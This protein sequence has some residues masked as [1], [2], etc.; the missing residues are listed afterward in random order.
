MRIG[1]IAGIVFAVAVSGQSR[2]SGTVVDA[3]GHAVRGAS[4]RLTPPDSKDAI[5]ATRTD[6]D[7]EF[8]FGAVVAGSYEVRVA[9]ES[10]QPVVEHITV[11]RG[12][13]V[14]LVVR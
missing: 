8:S 4:V 9:W 2:I 13:D 3:C 12:P 1:A 7:G 14:P 5:A 11:P 6:G 10:F